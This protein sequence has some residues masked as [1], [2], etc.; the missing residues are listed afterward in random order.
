V[1]TLERLSATKK[2]FRNA[3]ITSWFSAPEALA[4]KIAWYTN[5]EP[6]LEVLN[7]VFDRLEEV[8]PLIVQTFAQKYLVENHKTTVTLTG[9]TK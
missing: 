6:D 2:R 4:D 7:R 5:F 8:T 9:S 1:P 3:A